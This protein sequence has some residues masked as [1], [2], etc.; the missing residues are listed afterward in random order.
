MN[1][2]VPRPQ[3]RS[4]DCRRNSL[5]GG[6]RDLTVS[7]LLT[8]SS[9]LT[10]TRLYVKRLEQ[11]VAAIGLTL[12]ECRVLLYLVNHEG[13]RQVRLAELMNLEQMTLARCLDGLESF[14]C[15]ERRRDPADRRA[16]CIYFKASGKSLVDQIWQL[17]NVTD[18]EAFAGIPGR[19]RDLMVKILEKIRRNLAS[20]Q[21]LPQRASGGGPRKRPRSHGRGTQPARTGDVTGASRIEIDLSENATH[22]ERETLPEPQPPRS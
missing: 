3:H 21:A 9:L 10:E 12:P 2:R 4:G 16:R 17:M 15:L 8:L 13:I 14:G 6:P 18:R 5:P 22:A 19:H 7:A 1:V 20:L 11:R